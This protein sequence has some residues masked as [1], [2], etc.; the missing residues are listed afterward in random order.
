MPLPKHVVGHS[1]FANF[2]DIQILHAV[3]QPISLFL[4]KGFSVVAK[5][6][7]HVLW[8]LLF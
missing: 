3:V 5:V 7:L 2:F 6:T 1:T 8:L 4:Q